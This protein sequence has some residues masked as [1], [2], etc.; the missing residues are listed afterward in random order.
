MLILSCH[1]CGIASDVEDLNAGEIA[2][3]PRCNNHLLHTDRNP[4]QGPVC[5]A[6]AS[7]IAFLGSLFY[8]FMSF[9]LHGLS[10]KIS[11][12]QAMEVL[13]DFNNNTLSV[14]LILSVIV[15]PV[16]YL[17][18]LLYLY[19]CVSHPLLKKRRPKVQKRVLKVLSRIKPWLMVDVFLVGVLV[20]LVKISALANVSMGLS[21]WA[22][23]V[24]TFLMVKTI[25]SADLYWIWQQLFPTK[26]IE[27]DEVSGQSFQ[28][29][30]HLVCHVC[31]LVHPFSDETHHC[32]RCSAHLHRFEPE[33]N[34]QIVWALLL[35]SVVFYLPANL[36]PMMY[37]SALGSSEG[38][39]I[40]GGVIELWELGDY[41][42][43]LV[44]LFASIL[45]PIAKMLSLSFIY[46]HAKRAMHTPVE[47]S[48]NF[49]KLYRVTEFIGRWS[50][51]DIFVVSIL[52]A[53]V[54]LDGLMAIYP[55]PAALFFAAVVIF[56]MLSA[57]IFDSRMMWR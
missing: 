36:Y 16:V 21:F 41:P 13:A 2:R 4:V 12:M 9:S 32:T 38:S 37:T 34:L 51:I 1:E 25:S 52:V 3:C 56:T 14:L 23:F 18:C 48:Y 53:L 43:A 49:L 5:F 15:L 29:K 28:D 22:F 50:M 26:L 44:I 7:L 6:I 30:S 11:L 33:N 24:F 27:S 35:T 17:I 57:M 47:E 40:L 39:T 42:V 19:S 10:Q 8:P 20:S 31:G 45:I 46:W 55:G 54:Q